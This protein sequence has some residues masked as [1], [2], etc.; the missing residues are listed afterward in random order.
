M[1]GEVQEQFL[2]QWV[3]TCGVVYLFFEVGCGFAGSFAPEVCG[4]HH[5][6][7][8]HEGEEVGT[9]FQVLFGGFEGCFV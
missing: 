3:W 4:Q 2:S 8:L 6:F 9:V 5:A 7:V 1:I